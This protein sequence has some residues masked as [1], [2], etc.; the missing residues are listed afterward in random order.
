MSGEALHRF[1]RGPLLSQLVEQEA[2]AP[3]P[4]TVSTNAGW[5][6]SQPVAITAAPSKRA[7]ELS[8][9]GGTRRENGW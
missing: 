3:A 5:P 6:V 4:S 2:L 7:K 8:A 1:D 9:A